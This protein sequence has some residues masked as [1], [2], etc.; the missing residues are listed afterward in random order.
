MKRASENI[1]KEMS[2]RKLNVR[3]LGVLRRRDKGL[4]LNIEVAT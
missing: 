1:K 2:K 4:L 3:Y